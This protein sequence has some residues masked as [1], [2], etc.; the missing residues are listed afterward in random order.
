MPRPIFHEQTGH[1][2]RRTAEALPH[3][4]GVVGVEG[5]GL[6]TAARY[7]IEQMDAA[8]PLF[9]YPEKK[10]V[11]D[12]ID[13]TITIDV[14]RRLY[15][16]TQGRSTMRQ[17]IIITAADTMS[18]QAQNAFLK[19]LE[20]PTSTTSFILLIHH[21]DRLLPTVRSRLQLLRIR[22]ITRQQSEQLLDRLEVND[23]TTCRQILFLAEG[24]PA[25][26]TQLASDEATFVREATQL[27]HAK[28]LVQGTKYERLLVAESL[29]GSRQNAV[30]VVEYA[31]AIMRFDVMTKRSV[32]KQSIAFMIQLEVALR[33]LHANVNPRL[34]IAQVALAV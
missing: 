4:I 23:A 11:V 33:R 16:L 18:P 34:A 10:N 19:L 25:R 9:V 3:A 12:M 7:M 28:V 15:R 29:R 24:L 5:S 30:T 14:I 27:R 8:V 17:C 22:R 20:E 26:L 1:L 21:P 2:L 32:N 13:G 6:T 31:M